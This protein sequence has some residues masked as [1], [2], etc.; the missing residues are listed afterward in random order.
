[1]DRL[2]KGDC[3]RNSWSAGAPSCRYYADVYLLDAVNIPPG[4]VDRLAPALLPD[5]QAPIVVYCTGAGTSSDAVVELAPTHTFD[6]PIP[7]RGHVPGGGQPTL[8]ACGGR[9]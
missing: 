6:D 2:V 9:H 8:A 1:M 7:V 3:Q 4:H 5:R